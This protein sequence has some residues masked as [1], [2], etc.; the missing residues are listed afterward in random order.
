MSSIHFII[1]KQELK[2]QLMVKSTACFK[3]LKTNSKAYVFISGCLWKR[4]LSAKTMQRGLISVF[5]V[6]FCLLGLLKLQRGLESIYNFTYKYNGWKD[7]FSAL[8]DQR[9]PL[10]N[11][12]CINSHSLL[13]STEINSSFFLSSLSF[14]FS[15]GHDL[16]FT[17]VL[18]HMYQSVSWVHSDWNLTC[19]LS[20]PSKR[21]RFCILTLDSQ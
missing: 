9:N 12:L 5:I 20:F 17:W 16:N 7:F 14:N 6:R 10:E 18:N 2:Q 8:G 4:D 11:T 13:Y 19:Q 21:C 1:T 3:T 15:H